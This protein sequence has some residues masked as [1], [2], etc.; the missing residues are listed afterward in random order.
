MLTEARAERADFKDG[1]VV[2]GEGG[3][4]LLF[5]GVVVAPD[6][7]VVVAADAA[8]GFEGD[9]EE[10]DLEKGERG[11]VSNGALCL[12]RKRG[13]LVKILFLSLGSRRCAAAQMHREG[14]SDSLQ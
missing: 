7:P 3:D 13:G 10:E 5:L 6:R 12:V 11:R 1:I 14:A 8:E 2:L 9:D 4:D